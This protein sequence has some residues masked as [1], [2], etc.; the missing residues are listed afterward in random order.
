MI[1]N[2]FA[3]IEKRFNRVESLL[4]Q[5]TEPS[6]KSSNHLPQKL[7]TPEEA[8]NYLGIPESELVHLM[9]AGIIPFIQIGSFVRFNRQAVIT[10]L[11]KSK[12]IK[13]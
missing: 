11:E 1:D 3:V 10:A 2:P 9:D 4:V 8:S 6:P 7:D 12:K 5:L 13:N